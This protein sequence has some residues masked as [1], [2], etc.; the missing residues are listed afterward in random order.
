M[1]AC[2]NFFRQRRRDDLLETQNCKQR[3]IAMENIA[4]KQHI[5][6]KTFLF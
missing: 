5:A 2:P 3:E 6:S 4:K 1:G